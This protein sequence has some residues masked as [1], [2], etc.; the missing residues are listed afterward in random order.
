MTVS[1]SPHSQLIV[2]DW[3]NETK[4]INL[5]F[6]HMSPIGFMAKHFSSH[7]FGRHL[8]PEDRQATPAITGGH[9][10][11]IVAWQAWVAGCCRRM[12]AGV[13][14][15][16]GMKRVEMLHAWC[17]SGVNGRARAGHTTAAVEA[18]EDTAVDGRA[19][20]L[21]DIVRHHGQR[22]RRGQGFLQQ[23]RP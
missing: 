21:V 23:Q 5:F 16:P 3:P 12:H 22:R 7:K 11:F 19:A 1:Q 4:T 17:H 15:H 20:R 6:A 8:F 10:F 13:G 18:V 2:P 14:R 9:V